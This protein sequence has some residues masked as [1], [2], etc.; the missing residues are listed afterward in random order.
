MLVQ[1]G[2]SGMYLQN[3]NITTEYRLRIYG[4]LLQE[5]DIPI[6]ASCV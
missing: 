1:G 6:S 3:R 4:P 5:S 2:D